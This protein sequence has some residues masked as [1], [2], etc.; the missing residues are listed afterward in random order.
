MPVYALFGGFREA[1]LL[2]CWAS[3]ASSGEDAVNFVRATVA[4][5]VSSSLSQ[6]RV[7]SAGV[8]LVESWRNDALPSAQ[9]RAI[10]GE[11]ALKHCLASTDIDVGGVTGVP[12][13]S[14]RSNSRPAVVIIMSSDVLLEE[15]EVWAVNH[16]WSSGY[17]ASCI[18]I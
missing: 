17:S 14:H 1:M 8:P 10:M 3:Q 7:L 4:L 18:P 2:L 16:A 6:R 15:F 12:P 9:R 5:A 11:S 13:F